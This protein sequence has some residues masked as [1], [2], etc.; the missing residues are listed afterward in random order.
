MILH[1]LAT[2]GNG[3]EV[4]LLTFSSPFVYFSPPFLL[5]SILYSMYCLLSSILCLLLHPVLYIL[6]A[7]ERSVP[8]HLTRR[9]SLVTVTIA[10]MVPTTATR[11]WKAPA[12][13]SPVA[14]KAHENRPSPTWSKGTTTMKM[15]MTIVMRIRVRTVMMMMR[16]T[17]TLTRLAVMVRQGAIHL[18]PPPP[19]HPHAQLVN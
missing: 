19:P 15:M 16:W 3:R 5:Y 9:S 12:M 6:G 2:P 13:T 8:L 11:P 7:K 17:L 10:Q 4:S 1:C 18:S 14:R